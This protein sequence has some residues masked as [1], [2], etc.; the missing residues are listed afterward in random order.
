MDDVGF[1]RRRSLVRVFWPHRAIRRATRQPGGRGPGARGGG[2]VRRR[3]P[4]HLGNGDLGSLTAAGRPAAGARCTPA[5]ATIAAVAHAVGAEPAKNRAR[6]RPATETPSART[7]EETS[8]AARRSASRRGRGSARATA[9]ISLAGQGLAGD[10]VEHWSY[11]GSRRWEKR[12]AVVRHHPG[13]TS[14]QRRWHHF[15]NSDVA[16]QRWD[17]MITASRDSFQG[18]P[19]CVRG[20]GL[21]IHPLNNL[22]AQ[23]SSVPCSKSSTQFKNMMTLPNGYAHCATCRGAS[24]MDE[25]IRVHGHQ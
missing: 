20:V 18:L 24:N 3:V 17:L 12:V 10:P 23:I 7:V 1:D 25:K 11:C 16:R 15:K 5:A 19:R 4:R 22:D 6:R 9:P 14:G 8:A 2:R 21:G 13:P